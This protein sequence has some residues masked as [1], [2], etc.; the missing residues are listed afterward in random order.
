[1]CKKLIKHFTVW[2]KSKV[3]EKD[4]GD[5]PLEYLCIKK[6]DERSY[7]SSKLPIFFAWLWIIVSLY[8]AVQSKFYSWQT[9]NIILSLIFFT[10]TIFF[11][12][13][14]RKLFKDLEKN[15]EIT[16]DNLEIYNKVILEKLEKKEKSEKEYKEK[17]TN[18]LDEI[19]KNT[20]SK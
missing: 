4:L 9:K 10:L 1:M 17:I 11:I 5:K 20:K 3:D 18:L 2:I 12:I 19:R 16:N 6:E 13:R 7:Y 8:I 14:F 15:N